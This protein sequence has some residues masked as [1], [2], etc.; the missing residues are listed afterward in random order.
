MAASSRNI[1]VSIQM[2]VGEPDLQFVERAVVPIL[3]WWIEGQKMEL[4]DCRLKMQGV[5]VL[6]Q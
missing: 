1:L 3:V 2:E 6:K 4:G 5:G